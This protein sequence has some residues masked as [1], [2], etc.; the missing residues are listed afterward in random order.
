MKL[1]VLSASLL[2]ACVTMVAPLLE[3]HPP[4]QPGVININVSR[5]IQTVNYWA[6]G[7]TKVDFKGTEL[8][9]RAEGTAKVESKNG[10]LAVDADFKGLEDA[11]RFGPEYLVYVL[12]AITPEGRPNNLG[13]VI[14][15]DG[16]GK[17]QASTRLQTFGLIVTAEPYFA[18]SFPS[19][20]VVLENIA[21]QDTKGAV[22]TVNARFELLQ[23]GRYKDANLP[24]FNVDPKVPLDLYQARNAVR[25]AQWQKAPQYASESFASAQKAL[26][27]AEDYQARKQKNA[28]PTAAR[29]AVQMAE[30]ARTLSVKRQ[31]EEAAANERK[32]AADREAQAKAAQEAEAAARAAAQKQQAEAEA[33]A[34]R[35]KAAAAASAAA[36][37]QAQAASAA[38][39]RARAAAEASEREA[40]EKA[41][42]DRA[43]AEKAEAEK[44]ALRAKLLEQ[45]NR[46]L[47][48]TDTDR[49]LVVNMG[50]VLFDTAK[51]DLRQPAREALAKLSGI[52]LN[53]PSLRLKIEGHTD[54]TGTPQFNQKLSEQRA[55]AV[56]DYLVSQ[57][58]PMDSMATQGFGEANPVAD[59]KTAAGRQ[60]NR[61]VEIVVSGEVIGT[62]IGK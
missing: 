35:D 14:V 25:I 47:P 13:Q 27:Q 10:A 26:A 18:V 5:N 16:K 29:Q 62:K 54:S 22:D 21:R 53:Y 3:A 9:P 15:N 11:S 52:M 32:A 20:E 46:V 24:A 38:E 7:S 4:Q 59:N 41:A 37:A 50:D 44:Q 17:I 36:A 33:Q 1:T 49:G 48:T 39:A 31:A 45:F 28:V 51:S 57:G 56:R 60:Q 2:A 30:D 61:R 58:L 42:A 12:W 40:Q 6:R 34:A 43:A 8:T 55:A 23:R 19:D